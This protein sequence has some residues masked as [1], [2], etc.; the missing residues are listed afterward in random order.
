MAFG[1]KPSPFQSQWVRIEQAKKLQEE[2]PD[3]AKA[4]LENCYVDDIHCGHRNIEA[5]K[6]IVSEVDIILNKA[7]MHTH[8]MATNDPRVLEDI[9]DDRKAPGV[10]H[11]LLGVN[12]NSQED[13]IYIEVDMEILESNKITRRFMLKETA[14]PFDPIGLVQP[15]ILK[16]KM[17]IAETWIL[18]KEWDDVVPEELARR[19]INWCQSAKS[20][21]TM[22]TKRRYP[23][24]A[25]LKIFCDASKD[26][27]GVVAYLH[28][29][30][31]QVSLVYAK[32]KVASKDEKKAIENTIPRLE[33]KA[34]EAAAEANLFICEALQLDPKKTECFSD[35]TITLHRI[36][37]GP[38]PWKQWV[39]NRIIKILKG[40]AK[41]NWHYV[42]T[43]QNP[44]DIASRGC[45]GDELMDN[46]LWWNGPKFMVED[47]DSW[48]K[49]PGLGRNEWNIQ[50]LELQNKWILTAKAKL[51]SPEEVEW[52][53]WILD[54]VDKF[55]KLPKIIGIM[56]NVLKYLEIARGAAVPSEGELRERAMECLVKTAQWKAW[57]KECR[58]MANQEAPRDQPTGQIRKLECLM[59]VVGQVRVATRLPEHPFEE[60]RPILLP[61]DSKITEKIVLDEHANLKHQG[62]EHLIANL[63]RKYWILGARREIKRIVHK[64]KQRS[65]RQINLQPQRMSDLPM[66]RLSE[67]PWTFVSIDYFGPHFVKQWSNGEKQKS[68]V[69]GFVATCFA[70]RAVHLE[71][72]DKLSTQAFL[73]AFRRFCAR[74][75][76]PNKVWTDNA[77]CFRAGAK[78]IQALVESIDW[79]EVEQTA[80]VEGF[81]WIFTCSEAPHTNGIVERVVGLVKSAL[82][83]ALG[84]R[85][86]TPRQYETVLIEIEG[87]INSRPLYTKPSQE[88]PIA[89]TPFELLGGRAL[90]ALPIAK[91]Q[92]EEM[93]KRIG[94]VADFKHRFQILKS[95]RKKFYNQYIA[96]LGPRQ[97]WRE[98][99]VQDVK[100]GDVVVVK[101]EDKPHRLWGIAKVKEIIMGRD[102]LARKVILVK[103]NGQEIMRSIGHIAL[104]EAKE[105]QEEV[106]NKED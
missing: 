4:I 74:R 13:A 42:D 22:K 37:K 102:N 103:S 23:E 8:K 30:K 1:L 29:D 52:K 3:G 77:K 34:A 41:D 71:V 17:M 65:C 56:A 62:I 6:K 15:F 87:Q 25:K 2:Y 93:K 68:K 9:S 57:P 48:P 14:K 26:A 45:N 33:L 46:D 32:S 67:R 94:T 106:V 99:R 43:K 73:E 76:V 11:K 21:G 58:H 81:Q 44:A 50:N 89:V 28:D 63:R 40:T 86:L 51:E 83:G 38:E 80:N 55:E 7:N 53:T 98:L 10:E 35:S 88:G 27:Y 18:Q 100:A 39:A 47:E 66:E 60:S 85:I 31:G 20:I 5:C 24:N 19:F 12:W 70:T 104:L 92:E 82:R 69:W 54:L 16:G 36:A 75:G 72:V 84:S 64:C 59:D 49:A 101:E 97:K 96:A 105:G 91:V 95:F 79:K 90:A 61:K 78:Q